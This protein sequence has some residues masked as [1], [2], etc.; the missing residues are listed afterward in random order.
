[1]K[2]YVKATDDPDWEREIVDYPLFG[3]SWT[4]EVQEGFL[5]FKKLTGKMLNGIPVLD[6]G[7][8]PRF[9]IVWDEGVPDLEWLRDASFL[10]VMEKFAR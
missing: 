10:E 6:I 9:E 4:V 5:V 1:M 3:D 2:I 8:C 7:L